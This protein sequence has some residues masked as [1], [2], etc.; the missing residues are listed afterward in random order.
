MRPFTRFF[1]IS[2]SKF[3]RVPATTLLPRKSR[4]IPLFIG[5][6]T[7]T[8]PELPS[9]RTYLSTRVIS[10]SMLPAEVLV[11]TLPAM[12]LSRTLPPDVPVFSS[13]SM[14]LPWILPPDVSAMMLPFKPLSRMLP[15]DVSSFSVPSESVASILPPD[16]SRVI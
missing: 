3:L 10:S 6:F 13:P 9:T 12:L 1:S 2:P 16:V 15:P 11:S 5:S 7:R 4:S 8:L 14:L